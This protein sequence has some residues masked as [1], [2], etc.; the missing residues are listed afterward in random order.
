MVYV[1]K[2]KKAY[3]QKAKTIIAWQLIVL[4]VV[5]NL[6]LAHQIYDVRCKVNGKIVGWFVKAETCG[7]MAQATADS[8][9]L[10]RR[11]LVKDDADLFN[12]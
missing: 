5:L 3:R 4:S 10:A 12:H 11:D 7:E 8:Q 2:A 6:S 1:P 9:E